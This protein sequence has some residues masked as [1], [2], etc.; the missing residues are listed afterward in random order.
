LTNLKRKKTK[1]KPRPV[2]EN[3]IIAN[4]KTGNNNSSAP[5]RMKSKQEKTYNYYKNETKK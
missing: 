4:K 5:N 2:G 3:V 1:Q